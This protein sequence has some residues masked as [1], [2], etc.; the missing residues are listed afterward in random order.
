M[1]RS[2]EEDEIIH[3][4]VDD[5]SV[6]LAHLQLARLAIAKLEETPMRDLVTEA[7]RALGRLAALVK[8]WPPAD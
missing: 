3:T 7:E 8:T 6:A 1:D 4:I 5:L 2:P